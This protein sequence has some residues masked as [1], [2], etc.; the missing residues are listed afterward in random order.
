MSLEG[1]HIGRFR[2]LRLLGRGGM[3]E[4]YLAE[5]D[6]LR[7]HVA[8]KVIQAEYLDPEA[9]RLFEREAR[10]IAMLNHPHI[11]P[12]FDF[13]EASIHGTILTYMVMPFCQEGTL[14]A[15][16]Q[17]RRN[18]ALL[19]PPDVGCLVQQAATALQ[20]AHNHQIV[21]QD[22]KPSNF[23]IRNN[24]DASGCPDLMLADFGVAKSTSATASVSQS[25]RGTPTY[26]APEQ[27]EATPV[28]A[29]DQYALAIMAYE[30][31]TG[32]PPFQG[33]LGQVMYQHI[34]VTPQPPGTF[35]PRIPGDVDTVLLH[36]LAKK[37]EER[38]GSISAFARAFEQ[39]LLAESSSPTRASP[40]HEP[41]RSDFPT[42]LVISEAEARAGTN[43]ILALPGGKQVPISVPAGT[44][45]GQIIRFEGKVEPASEHDLPG[46]LILTITIAAP[47]EQALLSST[48][49]DATVIDSGS[50]PDAN[51]DATVINSGPVTDAKGVGELAPPSRATVS[52]ETRNRRHGLTALL[53]VG[54]ALLIAVGSSVGVFY[55]TR[56]N[57]QNPYPP[58]GTLALDDPLSDNSHGYK[59]PEG[60]DS[61]G[62]CAFTGGA[63]H[64]NA[65]QRPGKGCGPGPSF[66]DFAYQVQTTIV[67][68]NNGGGIFFRDDGNGNGYYFLIRQNNGTYEFGIYKNCDN[69][70]QILLAGSSSSINKGL[71]Q[72]NLLAVVASGSTIDLYVNHQKIGSV[73]DSSYSQGQIGVFVSDVNGPIE[74]AFSNAK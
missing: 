53:L 13:G 11:L 17:Q 74:M 23:L 45:N 12:L 64:V 18:T 22:V 41:K 25:V 4:V 24:E 61:L 5:D 35:N 15:W 21:H 27:W 33:G 39:A 57:Q 10:A 40:P 47:E 72:L 56:G 34:H 2:L 37:P 50:V 32:H 26:M 16:M 51:D 49:D 66:S 44:R 65:L 36:A 42:R 29:T 63:Y 14:A 62:T 9:T 48:P 67:N 59:W 54:L 60:S 31:L 71:N 58:Y 73:S 30:L 43:R 6:Q 46:A 3:G 69:C 28:P 52:T 68:G 70:F 1:S 55:F 19:S 20:Y 7:R 38:F 8:I